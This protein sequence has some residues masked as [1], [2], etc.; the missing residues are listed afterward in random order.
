MLLD[1]TGGMYFTLNGPAADVWT[2]LETPTSESGL[3]DTL[4][5]KYAVESDQCAQSVTRLLQDLADKG[6]AKPAA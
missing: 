3:V 1:L 2:A 4:T 6:L 5:A